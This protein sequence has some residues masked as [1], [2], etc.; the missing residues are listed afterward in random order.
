MIDL[1]CCLIESK[2]RCSSLWDV[3]RVE[4]TPSDDAK[5]FMASSGTTPAISWTSRVVIGAGGTV[6]DDS[7]DAD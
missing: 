4:S 6:E 3:G 7:L 5:L 2:F 1:T